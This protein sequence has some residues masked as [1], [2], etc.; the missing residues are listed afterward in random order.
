MTPGPRRPRGKERDPADRRSTLFERR[1]VSRRGDDSRAGDGGGAAKSR[2]AIIWVS[3]VSGSLSRRIFIYARGAEPVRTTNKRDAIKRGLA[4]FSV[5]VAAVVQ[6]SPRGLYTRPSHH[7][8]TD[9]VRFNRML[10]AG[11][12]G[13]LF[14]SGAS[15]ERRKNADSLA[16]TGCFLFVMLRQLPCK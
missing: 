11:F 6:L 13:N 1:F 16:C 2:P 15:S 5:R 8:V 14:I 10:S 7:C 3:F 4:L 12:M 9:R